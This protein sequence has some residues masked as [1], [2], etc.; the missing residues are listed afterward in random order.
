MTKSY[1]A[2]EDIESWCTKCKLELGHTIIAMVG[3]LPKRVKCNTCG[4]EH[5]YRSEPAVKMSAGTRTSGQKPKPRAKTHK[6]NLTLLAE[7]DRS[8]ARAYSTKGTFRENDLIE[9]PKF[10]LGL[11]LSTA[12]DNKI[13]VIFVDGPRLLIHNMG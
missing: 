2:G 10:G 6:N 4:S 7:A 9:H 8:R 5:N 3:N 11:V 1:S 12:K 13:E